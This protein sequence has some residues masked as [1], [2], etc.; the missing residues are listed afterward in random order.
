MVC[1]SVWGQ[2]QRATATD[3]IPPDFPADF[4]AASFR[5]VPPT[6]VFFIASAPPIWPWPS[7]RPCAMNSRSWKSPIAMR[8]AWCWR[9]CATTW[10][11]RATVPGMKQDE[12][13]WNNGSGMTSDKISYKIWDLMLQRCD[14]LGTRHVESEMNWEMCCSAHGQGHMFESTLAKVLLLGLRVALQNGTFHFVSLR[15]TFTDFDCM[16]YLVCENLRIHPQGCQFYAF[17]GPNCQTQTQ[18]QGRLEHN[19]ISHVLPVKT[20]RISGICL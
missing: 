8:S 19:M 5:Q 18:D 14:A 7:S 6:T 15:F 11:T 16:K 13:G 9:G 1:H 4:P 20:T 10:D 3:M 12:T 17:V 2:G